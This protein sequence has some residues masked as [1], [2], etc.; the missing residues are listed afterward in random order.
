M[1]LLHAFVRYKNL[2]RSFFR[3]V[4]IHA[5]DRQTDGRTDRQTAFLSLDRDCIPWRHNSATDWPIWKKFGTPMT[6]FEIETGSSN[7]SAMYWDISSKFGMQVDFLHSQTN[8]V[9]KHANWKGLRRHGRHL[10]N[11]Y[12]VITWPVGINLDEIWSVYSNHT[13]TAIELWRSSNNL[14]S[15]VITYVIIAKCLWQGHVTGP[16][17]PWIS[18]LA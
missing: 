11:R 16:L 14:L 8:A 3:F 13:H 15:L 5:C 9:T 7:N 1:L 6:V 4:T 18:M 12:D 17:F 10:K 2:D